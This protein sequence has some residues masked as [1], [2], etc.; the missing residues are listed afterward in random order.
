MKVDFVMSNHWMITEKAKKKWRK[1]GA[2]RQ[3][4]IKLK[5]INGKVEKIK[6]ALPICRLLCPFVLLC[7]FAKTDFPICP[8]H[9]PFFGKN[10]W[11]EKRHSRKCSHGKRINFWSLWHYLVFI[12]VVFL[13]SKSGILHENDYTIHVCRLFIVSMWLLLFYE[14]HTLSI[15]HTFLREKKPE[16]LVCSV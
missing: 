13:V 11:A 14:I 15:N 4:K 1:L 6:N 5:K 16:V 9:C 2:D 10:C 7:P 3:G 12:L 8:L